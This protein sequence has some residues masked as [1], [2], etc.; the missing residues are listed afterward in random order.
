MISI[1]IDKN[2]E[3]RSITLEPLG[4]ASTNMSVISTTIDVDQAWNQDLTDN[5]R[6]SY[7][8]PL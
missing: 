2:I 1:L 7:M 5:N 6:D 4:Q 3:K 8:D